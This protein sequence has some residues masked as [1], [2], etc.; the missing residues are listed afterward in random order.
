M[1]KQRHF[2][3]YTA[4]EL[5]G[6]EIRIEGPVRTPVGHKILVIAD[7]EEIGNVAKIELVMEPHEY[8]KA[9]LTLWRFDLFTVKD[10]LVVD[11]H[12]T[13]DVNVSF[14]AIVDEASQAEIP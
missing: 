12:Q 10:P 6:R 1:S 9:K 4:E 8:I 14:S 7:D 13:S 11:V 3:N 5:I 2:R